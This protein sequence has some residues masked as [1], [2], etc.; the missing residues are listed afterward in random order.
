MGDRMYQST[1][2]TKVSLASRK[3]MRT[4]SQ[5]L[6]TKLNAAIEDL[7]S[8]L[9]DELSESRIGLPPDMRAHLDRFRGALLTFYT[10]KFGSFPPSD[11]DSRVVQAMLE[12]F[13]ALYDLLVDDGIGAPGMFGGNNGGGLCIL[14]IIKGF[15]SRN[16][17]VARQHPLPLL[18]DT[19]GLRTRRMS[20]LGRGEMKKPSNRLVAHT[21]LIKASNWRDSKN[22]LVRMYRDF[23]GKSLEPAANK[24]DRSSLSITDARKVRWILI[25]AMCQVLRSISQ[26]AP[27]VAG[28]Q[29]PYFLSAP[30]ELPPWDIA[31]DNLNTTMELPIRISALPTMPPPTNEPWQPKFADEVE[32]K[33]DIDYF[34]LTH[35]ME[36]QQPAKLGRR[37]SMLSQT[38][39]SPTRRSS[40]KLVTGTGLERRSTI[41][42]SIKRRLRPGSATS[43]TSPTASKSVYHEIVVEGYGNGTNEVKLGRRNTVGCDNSEVALWSSATLPRVP[44]LAD[45][46]YPGIDSAAPAPNQSR[47]SS[48]RSSSASFIDATHSQAASGPASPATIATDEFEQTPAVEPIIVR[49]SS[50]R[51]LTHR[52]PMKAV[53]DTISRTSSKRRASFSGSKEPPPPVPLPPA[54]S[55]AGT[56]SRASSIRRSLLPESWSLPGRAMVAQDI[57]EE[58]EIVTLQS[59]ADEWIA[60]Q[61]FLDGD[62]SRT[63][64][65]D[66]AA[67]PGWEQYNDLGGLTEVR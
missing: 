53:L 12:D 64:M 57:C 37:Q 2:Y 58:D 27:Q 18:P 63:H 67:V 20:W 7:G 46:T 4:A 24:G 17:F 8:F 10:A 14:Q 50:H 51:S 52:Y 44:R 30:I 3:L 42:D 11:F 35:N 55:P 59:E 49:N 43:A 6:K 40:A 1:E 45:P 33:P 22:G 13:E 36:L 34:A 5:K 28:E 62:H 21:A 32:I 9:D 25:Y 16:S 23:E 19:S 54:A 66:E 15:D 61:A 41:R 31:L 29:A 26:T 39:A 65:D 38:T 60:M 48:H 47:S 56:P